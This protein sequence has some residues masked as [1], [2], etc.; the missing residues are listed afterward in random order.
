ML[1]SIA[2]N[3]SYVYNNM[4]T[5]RKGRSMLFPSRR[6][7]VW[8][9]INNNVSLIIKVAHTANYMSDSFST[10]AR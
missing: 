6:N 3:S 7:E 4:N 2:N 10:K 8:L 1:I 9:T 5:N